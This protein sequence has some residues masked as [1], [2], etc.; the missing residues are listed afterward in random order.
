[1]KVQKNYVRRLLTERRNQLTPEEV[2]EKS[3]EIIKKL[4][5]TAY[6]KN[7]RIILA[8][9]NIKNEV[10]TID[11]IEESLKQQKIVCLPLVIKSE[12]RIEIYKIDN[13]STD[14][15]IGTYG[16]PE[17]ILRSECRVDPEDINLVIVPGV[18]FDIRLNR[19][20][21]GGGF[22]DKFLANLKPGILKI[23][24]AYDFQVLSELPIE[25]FDVKM[26]MIITEKRILW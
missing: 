13:L 6:Y 16:I 1:M 24:L 4:K 20:G 12:G 8:Y 14:I 15:H 19:M 17:P 18:G 21:Y 26:D 11:F 25:S 7:S 22:Y 23:G 3:K 9:V 10:K 2:E 5:E